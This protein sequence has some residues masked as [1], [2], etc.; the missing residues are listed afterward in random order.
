MV[1]WNP[2][3]PSA[4]SVEVTLDMTT[5]NTQSAYRDKDVKGADWLNVDKFPTLTFKSTSV[6]R[7]G[8]GLKI[9]G[10]LTL[11]GVTKPVVLEATEPTPPV[12]GMQG[13]LATAVEAKTTLKRMDFNIGSKYPSAVVGDEVVLTIDVEMDQK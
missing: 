13:G 5:F 6:Q 4:N 7:A 1:L 8:K 10:N 2:K 3:D 11:A 12:K 9:A